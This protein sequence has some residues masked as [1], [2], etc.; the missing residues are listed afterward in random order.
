MKSKSILTPKQK[1]IFS[2]PVDENKRPKGKWSNVTRDQIVEVV[3]NIMSSE[4]QVNVVEYYWRDCPHGRYYYF[5]PLTQF[6]RS[7]EAKR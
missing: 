7:Y 1:K 5:K 6:L 3:N 2:E 4:L